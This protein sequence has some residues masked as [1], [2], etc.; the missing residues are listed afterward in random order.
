MLI[1]ESSVHAEFKGI[2]IIK[3]VELQLLVRLP[4]PPPIPGLRSPSME[5]VSVNVHQGQSKKPIFVYHPD[6]RTQR[7]L[8]GGSR[9]AVESFPLEMYWHPLSVD[10]SSF[11]MSF[12]LPA[13]VPSPSPS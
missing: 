11:V 8:V 12:F 5:N 13:G 3:N 6:P 4:P 9:G 7:T 1:Q 10:D 2:H